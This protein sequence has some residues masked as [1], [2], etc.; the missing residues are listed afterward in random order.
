MVPPP[1]AVAAPKM[2]RKI[3]GHPQSR[4]LAMVAIIPVVL[5]S[6]I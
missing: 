3:P 5:L 4:T 2:H 1:S 6:I